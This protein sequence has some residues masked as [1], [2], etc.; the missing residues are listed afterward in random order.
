MKTVQHHCPTLGADLAAEEDAEG[1]FAFFRGIP[2]ASVSQRWTQSHIQNTLPST[3]DATK[4]GPR[5][6]QPPHKSMIT[7]RS[8]SPVVEADEF[9][10]LNLNITVPVEAL[11]KA[12]QETAKSLLPVM[13]FVHGY[14]VSL[15]YLILLYAL[16]NVHK[17]ELSSMDP[18]PM[19]DITL[20]Y[21]RLLPKNTAIPS[22]WSKYSTV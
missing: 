8:P 20:S 10:C 9:A 2:Y 18:I 13:A 17:A 1:S 3:F 4:Y 12:G 14:A 19:L 21:F 11:P 7:V 16:F 15:F 6:P 22:S 5:C